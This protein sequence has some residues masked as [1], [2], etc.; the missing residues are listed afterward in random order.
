MPSCDGRPRRRQEV[1]GLADVRPV[2]RLAGGRHA[3]D[4]PLPDR[5]GTVDLAQPGPQAPVAA[6]VQRRAIGREQVEARDLVPGDVR[7]RVQG[8]AQ[9]LVDV[10]GGADRLADA[11]QDAHVRFGV[12]GRR[13]HRAPDQLV[14]LRQALV[15]VVLEGER[16]ALVVGAHEDRRHLDLRLA[17]RQGDREGR[18]AGG[19]AR[20][21]A[22]D[23]DAGGAQVDRRRFPLGAVL[24]TDPDRQR[25]NG[26]RRAPP[27]GLALLGLLLRVLARA[28]AVARCLG[29][30]LEARERL[31]QPP[32]RDGLAHEVEG[33]GSH[34]FLGLALG[35]SSRD[36]EDGDVQAANG[37]VLHEVEPAHARQAHVEEDRVGPL[38]SQGVERRLGRVRDHGLVPDLV[39]ELPEDVADRLIVVDYQD[40]HSVFAG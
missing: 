6:Q 39:E 16:V 1:G 8:D 27:L 34:G 37:F 21:V 30:R 33:A 32:Q 3:A 22:S 13:A 26:P 19:A 20:S 7:E 25:E 35:R 9:D 17:L 5:K 29:R 28:L 15:A 40:A 31:L 4:E 18:H 2:E 38:R 23:L 10:E 36:H 14:Q 24:L 11:V 12:D